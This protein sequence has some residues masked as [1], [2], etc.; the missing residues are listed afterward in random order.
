MYTESLERQKGRK[1]Y[2]NISAKASLLLMKTLSLDF[3]NLNEPP[4]EKLENR[5]TVARFLL[6]SVSFS[7]Q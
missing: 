1:K 2:L 5:Y 6:S 3:E 4:K 7:W